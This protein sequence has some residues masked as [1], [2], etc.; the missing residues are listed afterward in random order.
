MKSLV[1]NKE[2]LKHNVRI[3]KKIAEE[4]GRDEKHKTLKIIAVVKGNGYGLGI[5]EYSKFLVDN[6][7]SI[8]AVA[9]VEEALKLREKL[10]NVDILMLSS[11]AIKK[12]V[13]NLID[14][15]I[16]LSI[17]SKE[18]GEIAEEAAKEKQKEV[19][20]HIK[21]DTG[22]GRYGFR[23]DKKEEMLESIKKLKKVKI[24]GIF[25]H[26]SLAFYSKDKYSQKQFD[27]FINC[28]EYLKENKIETGMIHFCNS[29]AFLKYKGMRLNAVRI[30]SAFLGRLII[31]N[32]YDL[33]E[34]G[35]LKSNVAEIK[36]LPKGYNIGYSNS[37]TTKK[38]TTIA[39]IPV[40]ICRRV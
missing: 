2:D 23:Y 21:I 22:F 37:Y 35:Y 18:A 19:R 26:C 17:G 16:I 39:V 11:T 14:N 15:N 7:I 13:E 32:I 3:I 30:G 40:R 34:I 5:I 24:E 29:S 36:T 10:Q 12:D 1:I 38:E 4:T 6:G 31:P 33:K 9:T 28:I 20:A 27:R 8:L 25:S